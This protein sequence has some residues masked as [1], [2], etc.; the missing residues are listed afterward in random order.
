[1]HVFRVSLLAL[2][3]HSSFGAVSGW[4]WGKGILEGLA[5]EGRAGGLEPTIRWGEGKQEPGVGRGS[6][7]LPTHPPAEAGQAPD[8]IPSLPTPHPHIPF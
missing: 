4:E 2:P 3:P 8:G 5:P 1:M 7:P 6:N